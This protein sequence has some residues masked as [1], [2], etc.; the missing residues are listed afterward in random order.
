MQYL[1]LTNFPSWHAV[2]AANM[3]TSRK[4]V[5]RMGLF[6]KLCLGAVLAFGVAACGTLPRGAAV[7]SEII[8]SA[9][10][11]DADF[12][13]YPITRAF[14]PSV[15]HWPATGMRH[16]GWLSGSTGSIA[17]VIRPGDTVDV[18]IWDSSENSLLT[19]PGQRTANLTGMRV[20]E[21]GTIFVPYIG[22]VRVADRTP[23]S[24]RQLLQRQLEPIVPGSQV[25]L[26]MTEGRVNSVDLVGGV[27]APGNIILPDQNFSV[28]GAISA[29]GGVRQGIENPQVKLVR[30][31]KIY[32][33]SVSRLYESPS[34]DTRL[35]GGDKLIVEEDRRYF[36]S[37]G[38]AGSESQFTF[39][40]D[41]VSAL[42]ALAIIGGVSDG[43]ANPQGVLILREYPASALRAGQRGPRKERVVFTI[44]LTTSDGLFS[45][46]NFY[47]NSG[48]LVLATES[49]VNNVRTIVSLIGSGFGL[50]NVANGASN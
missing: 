8:G 41:R 4:A 42:D 17:Q 23:D 27:S 40:R 26:R 9:D 7:S 2:I 39:N 10:Q 46:R 47:I 6:T 22:K 30:G 49:P 29:A 11:P 35:R 13:V 5:L 12:A 1:A 14:L 15:T 33:T 45:A 36:L 43:R 25:Q 50:I 44:D 16:H 18:I 24:A 32:Q 48:D 28:L 20:S 31:H 21:T 3:A 34:L 19:V 38:A 37:L